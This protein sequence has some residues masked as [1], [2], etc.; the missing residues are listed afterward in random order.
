MRTAHPLS[1][2]VVTAGGARLGMALGLAAGLAIPPVA[3]QDHSHHQHDMAMDAEGMV[4]N[5]NR[6]QLPRGCAEISGDVAIEVQ[7]GH[8][9]AQGPGAMFGYS[10]HEFRVEP[11]A[12]V[13]VTFH[14]RDAV[15]HQWMVHGL[16]RYLY[17]AGMFHI[18][19]AGGA[20]R[21][22]IFIVPGDDATYL[23]H[24]DIAQH[25]E[26]GMKGQLVVGAGGDGLWAV[27]GVSAPFNRADYLP[28]RWL[29]W[30]GLAFFI[31][32]L[33]AWLATKR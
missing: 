6:D 27:P 5:E 12:R 3:A 26:K 25:M 15:R 28:D 24:C 7:A 18:E 21:E 10:L 17:P 32:A 1:F 8:E 9:F 23:V 20:T 19:A 31:G 2:R 14:N 30:A 33:A 13:S 4:M 29:A 11:C 22:G 16:P